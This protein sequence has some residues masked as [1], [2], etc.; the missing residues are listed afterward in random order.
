MNKGNFIVIVAKIFDDLKDEEINKKCNDIH[1]D[2][3]KKI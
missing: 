3:V 1:W 2:T